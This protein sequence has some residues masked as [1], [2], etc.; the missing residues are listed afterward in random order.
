MK[1]MIKV[2]SMAFATMFCAGAVVGCGGGGGT[3]G[4]STAGG[5]YEYDYTIS[6]QKLNYT[7]YG[8]LSAFSEIQKNTILEE[9]EKKFNVNIRL[10]NGG[11]DFRKK[12][13]TQMNSGKNIP[14]VFFT[15]P[16]ETSLV[17][18]VEDDCVVPL[19][20]YL[21]KIEE[22]TGK[23]ELKDMLNT[24][25][26]KNTTTINGINYF[27]PQIT[28]ISNHMLVVRKD[29]MKKWAAARNKAADYEP[30]G[31]TEFT[32]MLQY[33]HDEDPDGDGVD[34]TYGLGLNNNYDFTEAFMSAFGVTPSY[35]KKSDG[36]YTLSV[37]DEKYEN[38]VNWL[39]NGNDKGYIQKDF[40]AKT[41]SD[42]ANGFTGGK[43][44]AYVCINGGTYTNI[45]ASAEYQFMLGE[46]VVTAINFPSS[47]DGAYAG[48]PVGD[49]YYWG[50]YCIS[51]TAK[52]PYRLAKILDYIASAEGQTLLS[53]GV[54]DKHYSV[55]AQGNKIIT[56]E[57]LAAREAD[58]PILFHMKQPVEIKDANSP[59]YA[60]AR[61]SDG[62]GDLGYAFTPMAYKVE[63]GQLLYNVDYSLLFRNGA[64]QKAF[65]ENLVNLAKQNKVNYRLPTFLISDAK[66]I[67]ASRKCLD[68]AKNY[69]INIASGQY[70]QAEELTKL[71]TY[72][73]SENI[74]KVYT[75]L[76]EN[77]K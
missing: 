16:D 27:Y 42:S 49:Q 77:D 47:D 24:A 71:N 61:R 9:I 11:N 31:I 36:S 3:G 18:W 66:I 34:N 28:G 60:E 13:A 1:K 35:V 45:E 50:G 70:T 48:T 56:A 12:L 72:L 44:G 73:A 22:E 21:N 54:K 74:E 39:K 69:T 68:H 75:Y 65:D 37:F 59:L 52:E 15:I 4:G 57:N 58:N 20:G 33:F 25:Q 55:D 62:R 46:D 38:F 2:A 5:D 53:W 10:E 51:Y 30:V 23:S 32:D 8:S 40:F 76:K 7:F 67:E 6:D 41:E 29:W 43:I 17:S 64:E 63:N 26:L 14:D 19:N